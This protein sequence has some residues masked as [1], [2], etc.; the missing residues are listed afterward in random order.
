MWFRTHNSPTWHLAG[1]DDP[2]TN[3]YSPACCCR[4]PA[5]AAFVEKVPPK[6]SSCATCASILATTHRAKIHAVAGESRETPDAASA[7]RAPALGSGRMQASPVL[8]P[9]PALLDDD[10]AAEY[11]TVSPRQWSRLDAMGL[12]PAC[13]RL[14]TKTKRWRRRD[15]DRW[16]AAGVP[17]REEFG[18]A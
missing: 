10:L 11:C 5:K 7:E 8:R 15:L 3:I 9:W 2:A 18:E 4:G 12:I 1:Y 14:G 6:D 13:V 17:S 16:I